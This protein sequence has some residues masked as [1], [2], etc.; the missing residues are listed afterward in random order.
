MDWS[1]VRTGSPLVRNPPQS[2]SVGERGQEI[3]QF[4]PQTSHTIFEQTHM[5]VTEALQENLPTH[6]SPCPM[7]T[8]GQI[9]CD[10]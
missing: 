6:C 2:I 3:N 1:S 7:T 4:T 9:K 8:A 5:D 10:G